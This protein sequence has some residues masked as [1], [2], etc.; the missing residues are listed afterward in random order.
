MKFIKKN[1]LLVLA[2]ALILYLM[3]RVNVQKALVNEAEEILEGI[4][5]S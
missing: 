5:A 1:W 3:Y 4:A 2:G